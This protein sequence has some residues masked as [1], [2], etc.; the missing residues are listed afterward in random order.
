[1]V[2]KQNNYYK[3]KKIFFLL[4]FAFAF[5]GNIE[6][7]K[8]SRWLPPAY[9][10]RVPTASPTLMQSHL[11]FN[12]TN[13]ELYGYD[14]TTA[15]WGQYAK[16]PAYGELSI[17]ADTATFSFTASNAAA[18]DELTAG[19][20]SAD[21]A[22]NTDS[23]ITYN[24]A[25]NGIFRINY[26]ASFSFAEAVVMNGYVQVGTSPVT[27]SKFRQTVT[28]A[29]VERNSVAGSCIVQLAPGAVLKFM[30][31]SAHTGTDVLTV[32]EF[33]LNLVQID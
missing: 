31:Q 18:I 16:K 30:F 2:F 23:T 32:Y 8:I 25:A 27:R 14:R 24:G 9:S 7:Q 20:L 3:M 19:L 33:N 4:A 29:T 15:E 6:A 5:F 17:S 1:L 10:T 22:V 26:S 13:S 12:T 21:F 11:W 28:T